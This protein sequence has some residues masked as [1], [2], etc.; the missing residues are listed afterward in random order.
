MKRLRAL[1]LTIAAALSLGA[2][3]PALAA[4]V[5][6]DPPRD[7]RYP[8]KNQQL[9]IASG[10][11]EMNALF[12][13]AQ[14]RGAKPTMI[15]LH[16]LPGNERNFDLAQALRRV[17]WNV[18]TF[19]Y[20]G[21]WGSQGKFSY[22]GSIDDA[23]AA[24]AFIKSPA[25]A[26]YNIDKR[27][28][29]IGGHSYGGGI[30]GVLAARHPELA[31]LVLLDAFN[32]G[33][34]SRQA[35]A[36]GAAGRKELIAGLDDFGHSLSGAT[37]A[38]VADEMIAIEGKYDLLDETAKLKALP[39][40]SVY[41]R[42][43]IREQNVALVLALRKAGARRLSAV[44]INSDHGFADSRILVSQTVASWLRTLPRR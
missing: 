43:G 41:A 36:A 5:V 26:K 29:V 39:I 12:F 28:I 33:D 2:A 44:E 27:R 3:T 19:T 24:L 31:G 7:A 37:A 15:L 4:S 1:S 17:G 32:I 35:I 40:L 11:S 42:H 23:E 21:A 38:S 22:V 10:E 14:G 16:G 6:Q 9:L 8:A 34:G 18:L 25:A 30:A 20:R 13:L